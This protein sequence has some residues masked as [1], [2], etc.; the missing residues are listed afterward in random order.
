LVTI[1]DVHPSTLAWLGSF[2]GQQVSAL[3]VEDFAQCG[4]IEEL[5][6]KYGIDAD[7]I[8]ETMEA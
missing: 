1:L 4:N 3:G 7:A 2:G 6:R 5:Y 8:W